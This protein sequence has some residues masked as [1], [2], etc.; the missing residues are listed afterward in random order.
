VRQRLYAI[1]CGY[2]DGNDASRLAGGRCGGAH[3]A[4]PGGAAPSRRRPNG[5]WS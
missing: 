2:P 1:A 3:E 4:W 5:C